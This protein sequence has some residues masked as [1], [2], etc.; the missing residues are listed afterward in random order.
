MKTLRFFQL[1]LYQA[2]FFIG[3]TI[4]AII[5]LTPPDSNG[6]WL[7]AGYCFFGYMMMNILM[8]WF[9][10]SAWRYFFHSICYSVA[11][12]LIISIIM[13]IVVNQ[14]HIEG[15][16]GTAMVFLLVIY[17]PPGLLIV[18]LAKWIHHKLK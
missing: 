6:A 7:I 13:P 12:L 4:P 10:A 18:L 11:Y 16:E 2:L 5:I 9:A 3:L 17:H 15:S 8:L 14:M 1:P